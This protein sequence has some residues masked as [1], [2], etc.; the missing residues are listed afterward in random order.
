MYSASLMQRTQILYTPDISMITSR[1]GLKPGM[2]VV[3][4]GTG[5]CSLSVSIA[6][7]IFP[8]GH[9][10]TFEFNQMRYQKAKD[11]FIKLGLSDYVTVSHRDVLAEGFLLE[12]KV[13]KE[14][15]D[16]VFL[17]LPRPEEAVAHA[18]LILKKKGKICNFSPCI[19]QVQKVST[20]L[21]LEGFYDIR[22]FECL[23]REMKV[24]TFEYNSIY[25]T[26]QD[27]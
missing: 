24:D 10:F 17:D 16:A 4:S 15:V 26:P 21:A 1:L 12:D 8:S 5:T 19:E 18:Y 22:T 23:S 7:T 25:K 20:K 27:N 2:T 3:E 14:S 9:L 11:D 6:K 13:V